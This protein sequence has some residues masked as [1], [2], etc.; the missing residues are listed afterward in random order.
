LKAKGKTDS[1]IQDKIMELRE[2]EAERL[3]IGE[4]VL[5]Y[6][7]KLSG[8]RPLTDFFTKKAGPAPIEPEMF[9]MIPVKKSIGIEK[10]KELAEQKKS[11]PKLEEQILLPK[12]EVLQRIAK[13]KADKKAESTAKKR[14]SKK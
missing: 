12:P 1:E 7:N 2:K 13:N 8:N 5:S 11:S 14:V 6:R 9:D 4:I 3:L 10:I